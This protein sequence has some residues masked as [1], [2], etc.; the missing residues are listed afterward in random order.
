MDEGA[1]IDAQRQSQSRPPAWANTKCAMRSKTKKEPDSA[2]SRS[3]TLLIPS[4]STVT[5]ISLS[6]RESSS[7]WDIMMVIPTLR[8]ES[9]SRT[10]DCQGKAMRRIGLRSTS[11]TAGRVGQ[12]DA[13]A[14]LCI[15]SVA[16]I[17]AVP[18]ASASRGAGRGGR[19]AGGAMQQPNEDSDDN[20]GPP[21]AR[22]WAARAAAASIGAAC[23]IGARLTAG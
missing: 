22:G 19:I 1:R 11:C 3:A 2:G 5:S 10:P 4:G 9:G 18:E 17:Q 13:G 12:L 21:R 6:I 7:T 15:D 14:V 16:R 23:A 20:E 8:P